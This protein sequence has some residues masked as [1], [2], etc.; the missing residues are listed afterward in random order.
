ML[1]L[2]FGPTE[3]GKP[4]LLMIGYKKVIEEFVAQYFF[5]IKEPYS[6]SLLNLLLCI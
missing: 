5:K 2:E 3:K 1:H 4:F 6:I